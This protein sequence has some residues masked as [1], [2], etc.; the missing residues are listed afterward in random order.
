MA[1]I[2]SD[3]SQGCVCA[4]R[5]IRT[6]E[7]THAETITSICRRFFTGYIHYRVHECISHRIRFREE[8]AG[9]KGRSPKF[10]RNP[11]HPLWYVCG[12]T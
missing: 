7:N 9:T 5:K 3:F 2:F 6:M 4:N 11:F 12:D 1:N 10:I 8:T